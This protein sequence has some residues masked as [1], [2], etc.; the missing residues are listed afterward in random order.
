MFPTPNN[1]ISLVLYTRGGSTLAAWNL[2]NLIRMFCDDFE[3]I[4]PQK[5]RSAG[6]LMCL[7]AN[8]IVMTKQATLGPIGPTLQSHQLAPLIRARR[9][10]RCAPVSVEAVKGYLEF[11]KRNVGIKSD[12]G[13][14]QVAIDLANKVHPLVLGEIFRAQGQ[15]E[16]LANQLLT[17]QVKDAPKKKKITDFLISESGTHDYTI[18]RR[19]RH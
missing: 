9:R 5:A 16:F 7:G 14:A 3:I 8:R 1:N 12:A 6:T 11:V 10:K 19:V 2:A 15:I 18:N 13:L 4:V 17:H